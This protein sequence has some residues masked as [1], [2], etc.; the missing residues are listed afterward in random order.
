[1]LRPAVDLV[2]SHLLCP[3]ISR[4]V[5]LHHQR[6]VAEL[7]EGRLSDEDWRRVCVFTVEIVL[8]GGDCLE[9]QVGYCCFL[10][11]LHGRYIVLPGPVQKFSLVVRIQEP[12]DVVLTG[13]FILVL[14]FLLD[15]SLD[16]P[17]PE[18]LL[19]GGVGV[20]PQI[21]LI[22]DKVV[23]LEAIDAHVVP[24]HVSMTGLFLFAV[25]IFA[26]HG[27]ASAAGYL[28]TVLLG[29]SLLLHLHCLVQWVRLLL[30]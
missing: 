2:G 29:S 9:R 25:V 20:H 12:G 7:W 15:F 6:S 28:E 21:A 1:M 23:S 30:K 18:I 19:V 11:W 8:V 13:C 14:L 10:G 5:G 24:D 22:L 16:R 3:K 26:V 4:V 17:V 27:V